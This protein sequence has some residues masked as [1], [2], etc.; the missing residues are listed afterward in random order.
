M[1][2]NTIVIT[3][4]RHLTSPNTHVLPAP[5]LPRDLLRVVKE[6]PHDEAGDKP[7]R[8]RQRLDHLTQEEKMMRRKLK[9][10]VA[11][12]TAR[13]RKKLRMDQLEIQL[14]DLTEHI[15]E[16]TD[17]ASILTNKNTELSEEN[18][19]LQEKLSQSEG[20]Q[21]PG[22]N[23]DHGSLY[24][25]LPV[26]NTSTSGSGDGLGNAS[27]VRK[28][29]NVQSKAPTAS[30]ASKE[31]SNLRQVVGTA[32]TVLEP[33][34]DIDHAY[35]S[36]AHH[37][38]QD[39]NERL[40]PAEEDFISQLTSALEEVSNPI[41]SI[42][43]LPTVG[44]QRSETVKDVSTPDIVQ[45]YFDFG[46]ETSIFEEA[47]PLGSSEENRKNFEESSRIVSPVSKDQILDYLQDQ[48][49]GTSPRSVF[50]SESG[51]D[52]S[53]SPRYFASDDEHNMDFDMGSF[54]ELF[55]T[56]F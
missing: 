51:Y 10:R 31:A 49:P 37:I 9:N 4:P 26:G 29:G 52:S 56:L 24:T 22:S 50:G 41:H 2:T 5:L 17:L 54:S 25:V 19:T 46:M 33:T 18:E 48:L 38:E 13:D 34:W 30:V 1:S 53:S 40:T 43:D 3:L 35:S 16:L 42:K 21:H 32:A 39:S 45:E 28:P 7:P 11:A 55:P 8:K 6:E 15:A 12:Q 36:K 27:T 44:V 20:S 14:S 23:Q 47:E